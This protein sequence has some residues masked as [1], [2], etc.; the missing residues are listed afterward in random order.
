DLTVQAKDLGTSEP[1]I[2]PD[3]PLYPIKKVMR[4]IQLVLTFDPLQR[5]QV[6]ISQDNEKTLEAAKL[7]EKS[8]SRKTIDLALVTLAEVEKDFA[9][10][11]ENS[12]K[13]DKLRQAQPQK[14]DAIVDQIIR[15]GLA[16]QTV[17]SSIEDKVYGKDYVRVEKIRQNVLKDGVDSLLQLT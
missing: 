1:R 10:L 17:F 11:K 16:R 7:L 6:L 4:T 8:S 2:L 9:K 15:N 12:G 3:N 13:L 5:V 14:V